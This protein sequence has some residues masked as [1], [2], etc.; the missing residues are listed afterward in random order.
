MIIRDS[1]P[2]CIGAANESG[3][4]N[5]ET[6]VMF[7]HHF[8]KRS[9][10]S[11]DNP[12]LLLLHNHSSHLSVEAV[13]LCREHGVV[14]FSFLPHCSHRLQP[15]DLSKT[16]YR[17]N[18]QRR[19]TAVLTD[20]PEKIL[21]EEEKENVNEKKRKTVKRNLVE[22]KKNARKEKRKINNSSDEEDKTFCLV[23]QQLY[24]KKEEG[25][26]CTERKMCAR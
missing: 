5:E 11:P 8:I 19:T 20:T 24:S 17:E 26:Q 4:I 14:M 13:N 3:W 18:R 1:P 22:K 23:C 10:P 7:V 15:L 21:L 16:K 6:F 25:V 9:K 2:G 12:V